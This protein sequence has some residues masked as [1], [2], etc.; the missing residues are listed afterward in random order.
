M[1]PGHYSC[2]NR[3]EEETLFVRSAGIFSLF[4]I[5]WL[6][7]AVSQAEQNVLSWVV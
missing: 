3:A 1:A 2:R 7:I 4:I 6:I 5:S